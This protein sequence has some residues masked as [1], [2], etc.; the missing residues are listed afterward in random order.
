MANQ[1]ELTGAA[2]RVSMCNGIPQSPQEVSRMPVRVPGESCE[3][4]MNNVGTCSKNSEPQQY[5]S[6]N[7]CGDK[8]LSAKAAVV[9]GSTS[10]GSVGTLGRDGNCHELE[11]GL[12]DEA[13][14]RTSVRHVLRSQAMRRKSILMVP[15]WVSHGNNCFDTKVIALGMDKADA[16]NLDAQAHLD[17]LGKDA[18]G[19]AAKDTDQMNWTSGPPPHVKRMRPGREKKKSR[20]GVVEARV[21][22]GAIAL[23]PE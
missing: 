18:E 15:D 3:D 20:R 16:S 7:F 6:H 23:R 5:G 14:E 22:R 21:N 8:R 11:E 1:G 17:E 13:C 12:D 2:M 9:L 10:D 4:C 19:N